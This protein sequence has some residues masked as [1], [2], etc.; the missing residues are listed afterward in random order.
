MIEGYAKQVID[1]SQAMSMP[2]RDVEISNLH[3]SP[4]YRYNDKDDTEVFLGNTYQRKI[5][6]RF[7]ALAD[8]QKMIASLPQAKQ[9][10][11]NTGSFATSNADELR[12]QL[13]AQ[14]VDDARKTAEIM[15]KSV[16]KRIGTVHNISN[17]GFNVRYVTSEDSM[18]LD[19]VVVT[20]SRANAPAPPVVLR[21]GTIQLDQNVYIIYTLVD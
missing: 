9:V 8:L 16:G 2:E 10:R 14:A 1:L 12:R 20:G 13:L 15:A 18:T 19:R 6:L 5:K 17:Q 11:L 3:V 4:E 21:E 7:H